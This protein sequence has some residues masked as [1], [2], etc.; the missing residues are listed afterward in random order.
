MVELVKSVSQKTGLHEQ[1]ARVAV[2]VVVDYLQEKLPP[3]IAEQIERVLAG[4]D[5][6]QDVSSLA[7]GL[8]SIFDKK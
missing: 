7:E 3:P 6:R 5:L 4:A 2:E 1:I 8:S